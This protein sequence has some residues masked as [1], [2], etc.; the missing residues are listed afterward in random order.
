MGLILILAFI[1]GL[2]F[3]SERQKYHLNLKPP[4]VRPKLSRSKQLLSDEQ[5]VLFKRIENSHDHIF[6]TGKA[7]SGKSYLLQYLQVNTRKRLITLAPTGIAA[8]NVGGQTIHSLFKIKPGLNLP[9]DDHL[10]YKTLTLLKQIDTLLIDEVSMVRADLMD[11][12]DQRLRSARGCQAPFGGVQVILFGDLYQLPPIIN[13]QS[14]GK[15]LRENNGGYYFFN[16]RVWG[17]TS[18]KIYEL[19][20]VFRQQDDTFKFI[21]NQIRLGQINEQVLRRLNLRALVKPPDEGIVT[22][23]S[24]NK[25]VNE[26]NHQKLAELSTKEYVYQAETTG[27]ATAKDYL[28][29]TSLRLKVG[30]QII[31]THND[32]KKRWVNGSLG[33]VVDLSTGHIQVKINGSIYSVP[34]QTWPKLEYRYDPG[35][36]Q[37]ET[38]LVGQ[39]SQYP[40]RLAWAMTIHKSQGQT[41]QSCAIDLKEGVFTHGQA[42]VA[43]S[44]CR[45]LAGLYLLSPIMSSDISVDKQVTKFMQQAKEI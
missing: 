6:V 28:A 3:V 7:G 38:K 32:P 22:L 43:L 26:I 37:I 35:S 31:M 13:S 4:T 17:R 8:L 18:L 45:S 15:F 39:I 44:R 42:Y 2:I 5:T 25:L 40:I 36:K 29:Q 9:A 30:A 14:L 24:T 10:N 23:A 27:H 19:N 16:A 1:T 12:V 11:A 34:K 21:L 41:Y 20:N 33:R